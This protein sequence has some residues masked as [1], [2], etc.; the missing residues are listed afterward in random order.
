M[1]DAGGSDVVGKATIVLAAEGDQFD[2]DMVKHARSAG[3]FSESVTQ[4]SVKSVTALNTIGVAATQTAQQY[5]N[6]QTR[7]LE[8]LQRQVVAVEGGKIA[9]LELKAAQ[10]GLS[11]AAAPLIA[12]WRQLEA[13]QRA[14]AGAG[15]AVA[16]AAA[17]TAESEVAASAR[18][19]AL[20]AASLEK[21]AA[22]GREIEASRAAASAARELSEASKTAAPSTGASVSFA[23]QNRSLQ[24][25]ADQVNEVNRALASIGRGA[26]STKE[27]QTQTDKLLSLW[28]QGRISAEQYTAAVKQLDSSEL[29]L[30][31][32]S[33]Q[34]SAKAD[35]FI[36]KLKEQAA[37]AGMTSKQMLEYRAAQ[38]G[39]ANDATPFIEKIAASEK[40]MHGFSLESGGARRELGVLARELGRG[41][42]SA[43]SRSFSI[44][45][46]RSGL[47][48]TL[49]SPAVL[50]IGALVAVVATLSFGAYKA[51]EEQTKF[52]N[53]LVLTG[54]YAG[55]TA[56]GLHELASEASSAMGS[57]GSA[58]EAVLT[59]ASSGKFT[60]EQIG[61][62][63][64][65]A[66]EMEATTGKAVQKTVEQF[67]ELAKKPAEASAKLNEQ[68]HYLTQSVYDQIAALERQ[69]DAQ[70]A[71]NLAEQAYVDGM[72]T[73]TVQIRENQSLI[74]RGWDEAKRSAVGYFE[75]VVKFF[76]DNS[77]E[78]QIAD[79]KLRMASPGANDD[80]KRQFSA[81]IANLEQRGKA[82]ELAAAI[83]KE[84][85]SS[86]AA[87]IE[88]ARAI[89]T[90]SESIDKNIRKKVELAKLDERFSNMQF[91][92]QRTGDRNARLDNVDFT[93]DGKPLGGG[94][95]AQLRKDIE[96]RNKPKAAAKSSEVGIN[97]ELKALQGQFQEQERA[98]KQVNQNIKAQYD[99]G[100]LDTQQYLSAE[101]EAKKSALTKELQIADQQAEVAGR[102]RNTVA[103]EEA[104]NLQ[105][106]VRDEQ[107][108]NEEKY[109]NDS[110]SLM[111]KNRRDVQAYVDSLNAAYV[112]RK[113]AINNL[114]AGTGLG[115]VDRDELSRINQ[116]QQEYDK[117]AEALR[118]SME[119]GTAHGGISRGQYEQE[120]AALQT[121][122]QQRIDLERQFTA[123]L[124]ETQADG[125]SGATRFMANY[126]DAAANM[127]SQVEGMF[128]SAARGMEDAW[129][130]FVTTGKLSF[131]DLAKSVI[132]DIAKMQARA[133]ISGLF[134]FAISAAANYF[135][136]GAGAGAESSGAS[137]ADYWNSQA[138]GGVGFKANALGDVYASPSLHEYANTV[139]TKP[140][141]FAFAKGAGIA[142]EAGPEAIMPLTR[143]A[144][145]SLGVRSLG[146]GGQAPVIQIITDIDITQ[147]GAQSS[148]T[149]D[150]QNQ[151]AK[152]LASMVSESAKAV[153]YRECA[154]GGKI[155]RL[156]NG[157]GG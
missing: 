1:S 128:T 9:A 44:F 20:V 154:P 43:A 127:A 12:S 37:T 144:D 70:G 114:I 94:L 87:S 111:E 110:R 48:A 50:M 7:F 31:K 79:L 93:E 49:L 58:R 76:T 8:S 156:H 136:G 29:S 91:E 98:L 42:F 132:S 24:E 112:T 27:L 51:A 95:Y 108:A 157:M 96:E 71:A 11:D 82:Q 123:N 106:R 22:L 68:Y 15:I 150:T 104:R 4:S 153:V 151:T 73:R 74:A 10:L 134:N 113:Q 56:S 145:G 84:A 117:A 32:S 18:I 152:E 119:K 143:A 155:W 45:A 130:T 120:I 88:A 69:G 33:A 81:L 19:K 54:N 6:S 57:V 135:G 133:A 141:L 53:A 107:L 126:R 41:D 26:G 63:A 122:I 3:Q 40:A 138:G 75:S 142:G 2:A 77:I 148:T 25:T 115:D 17:Q 118:R 99:I 124:K 23:A 140:T 13:A 90:Q 36:A 46:E 121:N 30:V 125:W 139:L 47:M 14:S 97:T 78:R 137:T 100:L 92:A 147:A 59:L 103:L 102:K 67:E 72:A 39:V 38:L 64:K 55:T 65:T 129:A 62:I 146:G 60:S 105:K 80:D 35:E 131:S 16:Q 34:A 85:A 109:G 52:N 21:T 149:A 5:S 101:Y 28:Q 89:D 83:Q 116:L 86:S 66:V 61:M